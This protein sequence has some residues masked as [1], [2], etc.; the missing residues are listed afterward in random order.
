MLVQF[1]VDFRGKLTKEN[2]YLA[3]E[4]AEFETATAQALIDEGWAV[5][6]TSEPAPKSTPEIAPASPPS[7]P[8]VAPRKRQTS[9]GAL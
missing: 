9:G 6:V 1:R 4:R 2:Y 3:G 8:P 7:V 5:A